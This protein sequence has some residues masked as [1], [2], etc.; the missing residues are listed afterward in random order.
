VIVAEG[1]GSAHEVAEKIKLATGV[2]TRVT[3]LGHIQRGGTP[4]VRDG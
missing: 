2:E 4:L 3:T 1:A